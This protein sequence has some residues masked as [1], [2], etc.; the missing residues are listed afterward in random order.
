M[1]YSDFDR[2]MMRHALQLAEKALYL[3]SPNPRVG[4]VLTQAKDIIGEGTH[5][6]QEKI[7]QKYKHSM[8]P[9]R[10]VIAH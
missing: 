2:A 9:V 1:R 7:M 5:K 8:M 4:C 6:L 3:S 10:K